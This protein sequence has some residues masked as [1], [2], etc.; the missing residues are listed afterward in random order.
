VLNEERRR[1]IV[2]TLNREGRVLVGALAKHFRT[3]QVTIRKDLD[4]LQA[5]G[6]I[7]RRHGAPCRRGQVRWKIPLYGK[8]KAVSQGKVANRGRRCPAW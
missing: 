5:H 1:L 4:I 7:H 2:A 6:R 3:S 8:R